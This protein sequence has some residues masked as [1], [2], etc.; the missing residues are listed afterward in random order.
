MLSTQVR[1]T[2]RDA[3]EALERARDAD[4][5]DGV[6]VDALIMA[7][8]AADALTA[9][10][11]DLVGRLAPHGGIER[12]TGLPAQMFI[13]LQAHRPA[14]DARSICEA[15]ASLRAMP[16]TAGAFASG[17]LSWPLVRG[18]VHAVRYLD[19]E[20]RTVVD[21][22]VDAEVGRCADIEPEMLLERVDTEVARL[23]E[24]LRLARED[25]RHEGGFVAIQPRL[26]GDGGSLYAEADTEAFASI[27]EAI[28][29]AAARPANLDDDDPRSRAR[30][31]LD[32]LVAVCEQALT[33]S[34]ATKM[35]PRP[36][37][38]INLD[39][40]DPNP[41]AGA[42]LLWRARGRPGRLSSVGAET[43]LCDAEIQIITFDGARPIAVSDIA[44]DPSPK[45]RAALIARDGGCR[46]PGCNAP[47][48]WTDAHH[49]NRRGGHQTQNVDDLLLLCRRCHRRVHRHKWKIT[50]HKDGSIE[51]RHRGRSLTSHPRIRGPARE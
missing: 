7:L 43:L 21:R 23:R 42:R 24:D 47:A 45:A 12:A 26:G 16:A 48:A 41:A 39:V 20:G 31:R 49:R 32:G 38:L 51:F 9:A 25:R 15:A 8:R 33:G 17:R 11:V 18:I 13:G 3:F 1:S 30:Q 10:A 44:S 6:A 22:L 28:D 19:A 36:R 27:C 46:F 4:V 37:F 40:R 34:E 35:R 14:W 50:P 2:A 29:I 5:S